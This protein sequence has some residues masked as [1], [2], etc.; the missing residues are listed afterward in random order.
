MVCDGYPQNIQAKA[1]AL[2]MRRPILPRQHAKLETQTLLD[3]GPSPRLKNQTQIHRDQKI[4]IPELSREI[5]PEQFSNPDESRYFAQFHQQ[6][7]RHLAGYYD[8]SLWAKTVMQ[9]SEMEP[10]IRHAVISIGKRPYPKQ[11]AHY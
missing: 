2:V 3:A 1:P 10:S 4:T 6:T 7:A 11:K 5:F 8:P 9:A